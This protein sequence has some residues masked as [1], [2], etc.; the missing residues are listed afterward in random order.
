MA[1]DKRAKELRFMR[2][3]LN[4]ALVM[5]LLDGLT[6]YALFSFGGSMAFELNPIIR[7]L[8]EFHSV[9]FAIIVT[10]FIGFVALLYLEPYVVG[11]EGR[12]IYITALPFLYLSVC[13]LSNVRMLV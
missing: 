11:L 6:L 2:I 12:R 10:R 7:F 4:G 13:T 1:N 5:L 8:S 3:V 9:A